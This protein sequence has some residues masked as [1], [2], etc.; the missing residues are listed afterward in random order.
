ME[1]ELPV[2]LQGE[3]KLQLRLEGSQA[4]SCSHPDP[5]RHREP[6]WARGFARQRLP[7]ASQPSHPIGKHLAGE[8]C[9][10][11][12]P[13][14]EEQGGVGDH[15]QGMLPVGRQEQQRAQMATKEQHTHG[16][17]GNRDPSEDSHGTALQTESCQLCAC[18]LWDRGRTR[19]SQLLQTP[20]LFW[21][22]PIR[23]AAAPPPPCPDRQSK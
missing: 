7:P 10:K 9:P 22:F 23:T 18:R 12:S 13:T 15:G 19:T 1:P 20:P 14:P 17:S 2:A 6:N 5:S 21:F 11:H 16:T 4:P 8:C 3:M